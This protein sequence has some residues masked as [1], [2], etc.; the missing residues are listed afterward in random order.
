MMPA[1]GLVLAWEDQM[2]KTMSIAGTTVKQLARAPMGICCEVD[3]SK[4]PICHPPP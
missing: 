2:T 3:L 1:L 4:R